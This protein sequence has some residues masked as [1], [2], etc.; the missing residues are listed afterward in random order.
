MW[1]YVP[2]A[3]NNPPRRIVGITA[4][5]VMFLGFVLG[6]LLILGIWT[7]FQREVYWKAVAT[8]FVLFF[9]SIVT[10]GVVKGYYGLPPDKL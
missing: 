1:V 4:L 10:H 5:L 2:M 6:G 7:D 9:L 3:Q 8:V